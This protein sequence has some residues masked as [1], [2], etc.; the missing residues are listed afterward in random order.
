MK[1][2]LHPA[3]SQRDLVKCGEIREVGQLFAELQEITNWRILAE[4]LG[5]SVATIDSIE[6]DYRRLEIKKRESL[7][8]WFK[9]SQQPR[10]GHVI[11]V[12]VKMKQ[13]RTAKGIAKKYGCE[14]AEFEIAG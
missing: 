2:L 14:W 1:F 13:I 5:V 12:L 3:N 10:W 8:A 6:E 4:D 7:R 9:E 11:R